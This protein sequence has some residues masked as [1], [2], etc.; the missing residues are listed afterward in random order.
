[1]CYHSSNAKTFTVEKRIFPFAAGARA[2]IN[3]RKLTQERLHRSYFL[4]AE[5][6]TPWARQTGRF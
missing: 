4:K 1:M 6:A 2:R 3:E 5:K